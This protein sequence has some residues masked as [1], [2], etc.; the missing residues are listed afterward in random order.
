MTVCGFSV[1]LLFIAY[2]SGSGQFDFGGQ[3]PQDDDIHHN[4]SDPDR[5]EVFSSISSSGKMMPQ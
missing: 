4:H 3:V 2:S 5:T 1:T